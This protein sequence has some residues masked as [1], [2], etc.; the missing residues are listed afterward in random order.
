[1]AGPLGNPNCRF[2]MRKCLGESAELGQ[3]EPEPY[4]G[5]GREE[6]RKRS[7]ADYAGVREGLH[8]FQEERGGLLKLAL[9]EVHLRCPVLR[10]DLQ[11]GIS[12]FCSDAE[13]ASA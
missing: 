13:G 1:M 2:R 6:A 12:E 9:R 11:V 5:P 7:A 4:L 8:G 10:L 3:G